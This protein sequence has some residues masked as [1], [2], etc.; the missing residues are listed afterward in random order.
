MN[1]EIEQRDQAFN[2]FKQSE[3]R[4]GA[5]LQAAMDCIVTINQR[6]DII[7]FNPAAEQCFGMSRKS[8]LGQNFINLFI[9]KGSRTAAMSSLAQGFVVGDGLVLKRQNIAELSRSDGEEFPAEVVITQTTDTNQAQVEYTLHIRD[10]TRQIKLQTRLKQLAYNDPLTGLYNRTYFL[11]NLKQRIEFHSE[12]PGSVILMFLDL[13]QFKKIN[14]NLGHK[15]GDE[16]LCE[17]ARRLTRVTR[18]MDLV[19]RWGGDEFV[20]VLSGQVSQQDAEMKAK[21]ILE[22]MQQPVKLSKENLVVKT[23]IG[24]AVSE[25]GDINPEQLMQ[26]ADIAMYRAKQAGRNTYRVFLEEMSEKT[27]HQFELENALP[28]AIKRDHLE[29]FYQPKVSVS[30]SEVVGFE[31]LVRWQHPE[32]GLIMPSDFIPMVDETDVIIDLGEW[33]IKSVVKQL[34]TWRAEGATLLP[35]AINISGH[36]LHSAS[37][38]PFV[39]QL[40]VDYDLSGELLEFE[41]TEGVLT[42]HTEESLNAMKALK[43][44]G[45]RLSIDDFGTGYS[46]LSY[47]KKFPVDILKIDQAFIRECQFNRE[48]AAICKAIITLGKSLGLLII[49]EG[50]ETEEQL[51]FLKLNQCDIY[52]G[53]YFSRPVPVDKI[54]LLMAQRLPA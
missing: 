10:I 28:D 34:A 46:S 40:L 12:N 4:K 42:G 39:E 16:L 33:V 29:V 30:T 19:G 11:L 1:E 2:A 45:I 22:T 51:G 53:Y 5:I 17:V 18:E 7:E 49:A 43:K 54:P 14:D 36:H 38:P 37:L 32:Q 44:T 6:G 9:S 13:D 52:Q 25:H 27:K 20:I 24:I 26:R 31:A 8:V 3:F 47:L 41:I 35:V 21:Q 50:V 15:A 48:D 23:S